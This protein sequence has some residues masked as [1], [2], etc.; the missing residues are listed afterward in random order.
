[1]RRK[2][3]SFLQLR[4]FMPKN[5]LVIFSLAKFQWFAGSSKFEQNL[6]FNFSVYILFSTSGKPAM[7]DLCSCR[8]AIFLQDN[9]AAIVWWISLKYNLIRLLFFLLVIQVLFMQRLYLIS[10]RCV[11]LCQWIIS[12][13][14]GE[15]I[16]GTVKDF[17][18]L[19][20]NFNFGM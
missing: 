2:E 13:H 20:W 3:C 12:T 10:Q 8:L 1:M 17:V 19:C 6:F 15:E 5:P 9:C 11:L 7:I 16:E 4:S 14:V 18:A